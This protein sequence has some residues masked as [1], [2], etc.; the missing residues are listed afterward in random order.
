MSGIPLV[1]GFDVTVNKPLDIAR[2]IAADLT[3]RDAI[4]LG[5]RYEG[6]TTYVI[7][8]QTKFILIGGVTNAEWQ[9]DAAG[10]GSGDW[11]NNTQTGD[12]LLTLPDALY[13]ILL[14]DGGTTPIDQINGIEAGEDGQQLYI[15]NAYNQTVVIKNDG[16]VADADCIIM[17]GDY[18]LREFMTAMLIYNATVSR[19]LFAGFSDS[20]SNPTAVYFM[21]R[22]LAENHD[23]VINNDMVDKPLLR[24]DFSDSKWKYSNDGIVFNEMGGS[25]KTTVITT[26]TTVDVTVANCYFVDMTGGPVTLTLPDATTCLN[27]PIKAKIVQA[28]GF[29]LTVDSVFGDVEG[30]ATWESEDLNAGFTAVSDGVAWR[31]V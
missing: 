3:A 31:F 8:E 9:E 15:Y 30:A 29:K 10:G 21:G 4:P 28:L 22:G 1:D 11:V 26:S 27:T 16:A 20:S 7:A 6:M 14:G 19:W 24:F 23:I 18:L 12:V 2:A 17:N 13:V 5:I 25:V